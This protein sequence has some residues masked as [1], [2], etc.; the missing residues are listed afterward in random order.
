M[1]RIEI[2]DAKVPNPMMKPHQ[3]VHSDPPGIACTYGSISTNQTGSIMY[4]RN[5]IS[6]IGK[7]FMSRHLPVARILMPSA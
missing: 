1:R 6:A 7:A 5:I 2:G 4:C 3:T